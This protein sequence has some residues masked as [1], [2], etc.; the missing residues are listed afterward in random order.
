MA[1]RALA[2][3]PLQTSD[4]LDLVIDHDGPASYNNTGTFGTSGEQ[5]NAADLGIGGFEYVECDD[6]SS[7][8]LNSIQIVL[9]ATTAGATNL[10]PAPSAQQPGAAVQTFVI[11]WYVLATGAEV[12]NAVNLSGKYVRIRIRGV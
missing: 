2:G 4:K 8:G 3:Y 10:Q 6:I 7:D 5:I 12:V 11:H 9:G 1:N